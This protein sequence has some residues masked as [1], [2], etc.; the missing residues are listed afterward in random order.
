MLFRGRERETPFVS[1]SKAEMLLLIDSKGWL[2]D[3]REVFSFKNIEITKR[4]LLLFTFKE[5][6]MKMLGNISETI[7]E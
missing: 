5:G 4:S 2:S 1:R 3:P 6:E 7:S